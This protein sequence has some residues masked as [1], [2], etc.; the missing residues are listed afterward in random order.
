MPSAWPDGSPIQP[1]ELLIIAA[2]PGNSVTASAVFELTVPRPT[3]SV[4]PY[5]QLQ[6]RS[7]GPGTSVVAGGGGFPAN[8]T[9]NI[10]LGGL[11][12]ASS[13]SSQPSAYASGPS[14]GN[15]NYRLSFIMPDTWADGTA[16]EPGKL[17]V[18]AATNGFAQQ[19][20][21]LFDYRRSDSNATV[22]ISPTSGGAGSVVTITGE[23]YP[24]N[25]S[26]TIYLGTFDESAGAGNPHLY[27]TARTDVSGKFSTAITMPAVWPNGAPV[28]NGEL[29]IWVRTDDAG[30]QQSAVFTYTGA[31][32]TTPT[33]TPTPVDTPAVPPTP[34]PNPNAKV[35]P[36]SGSGGTQVIVTGGGFPV[37]TTVNA[38]ISFFDANGGGGDA[39][40][41]GTATTNANGDYSISFTMPSTLQG[42]EPIVSGMVMIVVATGDYRVSASIPFDYV[43]V[44]AADEV[45]P[46]TPSP[47]PTIEPSP[48]PSPEASPEASPEPSPEGTAEVTPEVEE[49]AES[50]T[51]EPEATGTVEPDE[52][53][54]TE[55]P[56]TEEV[57][58]E[59][60]EE[61][62]EEVTEVVTDEPTLMSR[63]P[64]MMNWCQR[65]S[66]R[67]SQLTNRL[68][69]LRLLSPRA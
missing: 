50:E 8:T 57:T 35:S 47:E 69:R 66:H 62:A 43:G 3:V 6:P 21:A 52:E 37:N 7:G 22:S 27:G 14:D 15:G 5:L 2:T 30:D 1:G 9:I 10:Y 61:V 18:V 42:G 58:E 45:V 17:N 44:A 53:V 32:A 16:I 26:V 49:T 24:S 19:A 33:N 67:L 59:A 41:F 20:S 68:K 46:V 65:Q 55:E 31:P 12:S 54:A 63:P 28:A 48:V 56:P 4:D 23:G 29:V 34:T 13:V 38:L 25:K 11:V 36:T 40:I 64:G 51:P 39:E 60:T